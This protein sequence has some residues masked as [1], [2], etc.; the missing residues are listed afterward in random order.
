MKLLA[1]TRVR[2][3]KDI[4]KLRAGAVGSVLTD[5]NGQIGVSWD[6]FNDGW[7]V[8]SYNSGWGVHSKYLEIIEE[9]VE[10]VGSWM[11]KV[12]DEVVL[13]KSGK[14]WNEDMDIYDGRRVVVT[15]VDYA[16]GVGTCIK[17]ADC[18]IWNWCLERGH[19][20]KATDNI[21]R[22]A[23]GDFVSSEDD[24][25]I[26]TK[27]G[28]KLRVGD[29][30]V[31]TRGIRSWNTEMER[32]V[33]KVVQISKII[34]SE[35]KSHHHRISFKEGGN[36]CWRYDY[37]HFVSCDEHITRDCLTYNLK[38]E[39]SHDSINFFDEK[40]KSVAT[41]EEINKLTEIPTFNF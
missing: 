20:K 26:L 36:W 35:F 40:N 5:Y 10:T 39:E 27:S 12:G 3:N 1:G 16:S 31:I 32:L 15:R 13:T 19:F 28:A 14:N 29:S 38:S 33:G 30:V 9:T 23:S 7:S 37:G 17:F 41:Q 6:D 11:P 21:S 24:L 25:F 34:P 22:G 18:S 2:L 4:D 8:G